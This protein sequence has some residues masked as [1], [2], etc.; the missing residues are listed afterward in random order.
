MT[1]GAEPAFVG[2]GV[3]TDAEA[4]DGTVDVGEVLNCEAGVVADIDDVTVLGIAVED[5]DDKEL[6]FV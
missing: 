5:G 4:L 3:E 1:W 6:V 2:S